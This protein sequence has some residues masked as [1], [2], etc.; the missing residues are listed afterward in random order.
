MSKQFSCFQLQHNLSK[1]RCQLVCWVHSRRHK[2][3]QR[4]QGNGATLLLDGFFRVAAFQRYVGCFVAVGQAFSTLPRHS[5][6]LP[7]RLAGFCVWRKRCLS[8]RIS[9]LST[10]AKPKLL[11]VLVLS[12]VSI[13]MEYSHEIGIFSHYFSNNFKIFNIYF[14]I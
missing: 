5:T 6:T 8:R 3:K 9:R 12:V 11:S 7:I 13:C 1:G 14:L 2:A 10:S 4:T